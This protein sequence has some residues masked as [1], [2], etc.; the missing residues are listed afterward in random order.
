M[1]PAS[2]RL[3]CFTL[4]CLCVKLISAGP[5]LIV[6]FVV[7]CVASSC[8]L[9]NINTFYY[10]IWPY[11]QLYSAVSFFYVPHGSTTPLHTVLPPP[12]AVSSQPLAHLTHLC[13]MGLGQVPCVSFLGGRVQ[14]SLVARRNHDSAVLA[15]LPGVGPAVATGPLS[16]TTGALELTK[17]TFVASIGSYLHNRIN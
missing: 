13:E 6:R 1:W 4:Q 5:K 2:L 14:A 16:V 9:V 11:I 3:H 12:A 7:Q 17:Q 10:N 15:L 8:I